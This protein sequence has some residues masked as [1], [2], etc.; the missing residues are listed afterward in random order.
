MM[1]IFFCFVALALA[2]AHYWKLRKELNKVYVELSDALAG[3]WGAR[4]EL[5][6]VRQELLEVECECS[7]LVHELNQVYTSQH[8]W[9]RVQQK[10][11]ART[12]AILEEEKFRGDYETHKATAFQEHVK[13]L[14]A[15]YP[16]L[17]D[18]ADL[19]QL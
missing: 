19:D 16:P 3:E 8:H 14:L 5:S 11:S 4:L 12:M 10:L 1:F 17:P 7:K 13:E 2:I 18:P 9:L 15:A 6:H